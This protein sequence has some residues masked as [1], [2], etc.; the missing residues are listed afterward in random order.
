MGYEIAVDGA[1]ATAWI[2]YQFYV[3]STFSHCGVN[4]FQ[5]FKSKDGWKIIQITDTCRRE[6]CEE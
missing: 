5:L 3:G 6:G 1:L 4:A 2:L